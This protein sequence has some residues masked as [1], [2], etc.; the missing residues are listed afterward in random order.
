MTQHRFELDNAEHIPV[1]ASLGR[2]EAHLRLPE[3]REVFFAGAAEKFVP[4]HRLAERAA[5]PPVFVG[6]PV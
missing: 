1:L 4:S 2:E 6:A 3:L 5:A